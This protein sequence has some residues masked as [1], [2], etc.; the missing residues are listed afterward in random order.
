MSARPSKEDG[1][2]QTEKADM[3]REESRAKE[4]QGKCKNEK[5]PS[6]SKR[7]SGEVVEPSKKEAAERI[8][9][10]DETPARSTRPTARTR[11]RCDPPDP[12]LSRRRPRS[13]V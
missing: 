7:V 4:N 13:P 2:W 11:A 12:G 6:E 5:D 8:D 3:P 10:A 9:A 1:K